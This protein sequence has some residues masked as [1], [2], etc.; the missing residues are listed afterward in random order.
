[1]QIRL[2][3]V[4]LASG[5]RR[6]PLLNTPIALGSDFS[7]LPTR[8]NNRRACRIQ[9]N[10]TEIA[11]FHAVIVEENGLLTI[12][13]QDSEGGLTINHQPRLREY[14]NVGDLICMGNIQIL[15][16]S[17]SLPTGITNVP[18]NPITDIP[19]YIG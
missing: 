19:D 13:D 11:I 10:D 8:I 2:S 12:I 9:L 16:S 5:D 18:F 17:A 1:M 14:L 6:D 15:V 3:W 4:D 7:S